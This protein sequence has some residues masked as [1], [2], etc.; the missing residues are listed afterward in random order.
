M[1]PVNSSNDEN[2]PYHIATYITRE[3]GLVS[4]DGH[5]QPQ[6]FLPTNPSN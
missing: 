1:T 2:I 6:V 5:F 3:K 4:T